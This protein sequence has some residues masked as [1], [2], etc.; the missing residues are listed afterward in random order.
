MIIEQIKQVHAVLCEHPSYSKWFAAEDNDHAIEGSVACDLY[1]AMLMIREQ[2]ARMDKREL[3]AAKLGTIVD[4]CIEIGIVNQKQAAALEA[5]EAEAQM[6]RLA[7]HGIK[8][9]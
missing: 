1:C 7:W 4:G 8:P 6:E 2:A 9:N 3:A 5:A